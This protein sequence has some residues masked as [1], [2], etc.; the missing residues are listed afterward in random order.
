MFL[1]TVCHHLTVNT[2]GVTS[3]ELLVVF[4]FK[5]ESGPNGTSK[6]PS[7]SQFHKEDR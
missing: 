3:M 5:N 1:A 7:Q 2:K 6:F 4:I